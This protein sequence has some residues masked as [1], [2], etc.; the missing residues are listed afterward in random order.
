MEPMRRSLFLLLAICVAAVLP[1]FAEEQAI[2]G[3]KLIGKWKYEAD[4]GERVV[5]YD[6]RADGTFVAQLQHG[7]EVARRLSGR[8]AVEDVTLVMIYDNDSHAIMEPGRRDHE[9]IMRVDETSFTIEF[10]GEHRRTYW[11]DK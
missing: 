8:W 9:R 7:G 10:P 5:R 6:F 2:D 3:K 11:R 4:N 1:A